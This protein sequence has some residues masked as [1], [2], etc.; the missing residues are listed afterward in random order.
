MK[1]TAGKILTTVNAPYKKH[2][3][4]EELAKAIV[5]PQSAVMFNANVGSFFSEVRLDL[6][7]AFIEEW[8]LDRAAVQ[9]VALKFQEGSGQDLP[10]AASV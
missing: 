10:L 7:I 4:A 3:T 8:N 2:L 6:Q 9:A 5:D 1:N